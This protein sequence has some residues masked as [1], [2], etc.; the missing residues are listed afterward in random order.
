MASPPVDQLALAPVVEFAQT[1]T[2]VVSKNKIPA[3]PDQPPAAVA[4]PAP[5]AQPPQQQPAAGARGS[6]EAI[7]ATEEATVERRPAPKAKAMPGAMIRVQPPPAEAQGQL[8]H[9]HPLVA[10]LSTWVPQVPADQQQRP[11]PVDFWTT[12]RG[13]VAL[14]NAL[15]GVLRHNARD[16][17]QLYRQQN[18]LPRLLKSTPVWAEATTVAAQLV[19]DR[20][21]P[22]RMS[23]ILDIIDLTTRNDIDAFLHYWSHQDDGTV[24]H[25]FAA[26]PAVP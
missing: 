10:P 24:Q 4:T 8:R 2:I 21:E 1:E 14:R 19:F 22:P 9:M 25:W 11:P 3:Q 5:L 15:W 16:E 7:E 20:H 17:L 6:N 13:K 18:H 26:N 12:E 23:H